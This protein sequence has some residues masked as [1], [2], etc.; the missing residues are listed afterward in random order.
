VT[1]IL[2]LDARELIEGD[3][4]IRLT[5]RQCAVLDT[6]AHCPGTV[7]HETLIRAAYRGDAPACAASVIGQAIHFLR[8]DMIRCGLPVLV[9]TV[10]GLGYALHRP[11]EVRTALPAPVVIPGD[12]RGTLESLLRTHPDWTMAQP[13]LAALAAA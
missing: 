7:R 13:V 12:L 11:I 2:D 5:G 3:C 4:H 6:L 9:K 8:C 1:A 10:Y